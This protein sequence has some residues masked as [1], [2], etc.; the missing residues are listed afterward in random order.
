[1][2]GVC[3][4]G[5]NLVRVGG[6]KG[7]LDDGLD[8][9]CGLR[10]RGA[11]ATYQSMD[12]LAFHRSASHAAMQGDLNKLRGRFLSNPRARSLI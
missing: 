11:T 10:P 9:E 4:H 8:C 5:I 6:A 2:Q 12:E 1:M 3:F 7:M